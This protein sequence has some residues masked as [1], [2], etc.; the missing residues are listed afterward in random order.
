METFKASV[1]YN[2]MRGSAAA[3]G[4]DKENA[5][6]WLKDNNLISD[7]EI[8]AGIKMWA[9]ENHGKHDDPVYVTFFVTDLKGQPDLSSLLAA[10]GDV[11][12][13][14]SVS[15]D[16]NLID[17]F[18]LFKRLEITLSNGGMLEGK[19]YPYE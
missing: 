17:F 18:G 14:R 2:D 12:E 10:G 3:D 6:K 16:I 5:T 13:A 4:A 8:V 1:Q 11:I 15:V 19:S 9:G 7:D